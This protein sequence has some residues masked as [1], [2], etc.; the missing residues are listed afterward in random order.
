VVYIYTKAAFHDVLEQTSWICRTYLCKLFGS[1]GYLLDLSHPL[2]SK[3]PFARI[4]PGFYHA[5]TVDLI[6]TMKICLLLGPLCFFTTT[7]AAFTGLGAPYST[8]YCAYACNGVLTNAHLSCTEIS[9]GHGHHM[10]RMEMMA[11]TSPDCRAGDDAFLTSLAYCIKSYCTTISIGAIEKYWAIQVTGDA[12]V[13]AKWNFATALDAVNGTPPVT[14]TKEDTLNST[15]LVAEEAW[16]IQ[17]KFFDTMDY[18]SYIMYKYSSVYSSSLRP[19][20]DMRQD[21]SSCGWLWY[22]N[23]VHIDI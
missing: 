15:M 16:S 2:Y 17:Y 9:H 19:I 23:C 20:F 18:N 8:P 4:Y 10:R 12:S 1:R 21:C 14:W 3:H 22:T 7:F 11:M 13:P 6:V 5:F